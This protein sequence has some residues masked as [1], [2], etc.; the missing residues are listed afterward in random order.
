MHSS[1][2]NRAKLNS[3]YSE[4]KQSRTMVS[5]MYNKVT[6]LVIFVFLFC[7]DWGSSM[8]KFPQLCSLFLMNCD[9][10]AS[11]CKNR[12]VNGSKCALERGRKL[13]T[14]NFC[15]DVWL[16]ALFGVYYIQTF[17]GCCRSVGYYNIITSHHQDR[18]TNNFS[19]ST[20]IIYS[21]MNVV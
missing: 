21:E 13:L 15:R 8:R 20:R 18:Y 5:Y 3:S 9:T 17:S 7:H 14:H 12:R 10:V 1:L 16:W 6:P 2:I 19:S 11:I 4:S